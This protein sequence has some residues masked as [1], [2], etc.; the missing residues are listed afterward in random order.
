M[1]W[2]EFIERL[3][4][5]LKIMQREFGTSEAAGSSK[6]SEASGTQLRQVWH[7]RGEASGAGGAVTLIKRE[8]NCV[9]CFNEQGQSHRTMR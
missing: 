3:S 9:L 2:L 5:I 4:I 8:L 7:G 1:L 6:T